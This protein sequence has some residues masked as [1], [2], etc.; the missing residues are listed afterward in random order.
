MDVK[1]TSHM[2]NG[3]GGIAGSGGS[4]G[5]AKGEDLLSESVQKRWVRMTNRFYQKIDLYDMQWDGLDTSQ[6]H[7][8]ISPFGGLIA[9]APDDSKRSINYAKPQAMALKNKV[10]VY[11]SSG[12]FVSEFRWPYKGLVGM[13]WT[14][15]EHLVVVIAEGKENIFLYSMHGECISSFGL[16]DCKTVAECSIWGSGLV[17]RAAGTKCEFYAVQN[18]RKPRITRLRSP[19]TAFKPSAMVPIPAELSSTRSLQVLLASPMGP[20]HII[21]HSEPR[22]VHGTARD[23]RAFNEPFLRM[24]LSPSGR[25]VATVNKTGTLTV[26]E[27]DF[28]TTV[29]EFITRHSKPPLD[30]AWCGE[31]SV[32]LYWE[33]ILI[34]VGPF[35]AY[36]A[37]KYPRTAPGSLK[38][39][40]E[41]DGCRVITSNKCELLRRVPEANV[42][43]FKNGS[44][45]PGALVLTASRAYERSDIAADVCIRQLK[46][47]SKDGQ[48]LL[49]EGVSTCLEAALN[50]FDTE[51][52]TALL[53]A[54]SY[55]KLFCE[56]R[57]GDLRE[58]FVERCRWVRVLHNVRS[59]SVGIP[60][61]FS[62]FE[63]LGLEVL[64][65]RLVQRHEHLLALRIC[66]LMQLN[67]NKQRVLEHWACARIRSSDTDDYRRLGEEI[68][69]KLKI[70]PGISFGKIASTA[71]TS[72]LKDLATMVLEQEPRAADQVNLLLSMEQEERALRKAVESR[73]SDLIYTVL[74]F[75]L[76][77]ARIT[78]GL[79]KARDEDEAEAQANFFSLLRRYPIVLRHLVAY[80]EGSGLDNLS[81]AGRGAV[82]ALKRLFYEMKMERE[83]AKVKVVESYLK[84][85]WKQRIRMLE[86]ATDLFKGDPFA[87]TTTKAQIRLLQIQRTFEF[88]YKKSFIDLSVS[89]TI[90][91]LIR[92]GHTDKA[93]RI[94]KEFAV[95]DKRYWH[96]Q[97]KTL[98][99]ELDWNGLS[100]LA[101]SR[102][103][104]P[105]GW[106]PFIE[107]CVDNEAISEAVKYVSKLS[108]PHD[109]MEW[110]CSMK[111]YGEAAEVAH[112]DRNVDAL[113]F[114]SSRA[115]SKPGVK[116]RIAEMIKEIGG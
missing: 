88:D 61:T 10:R 40:T 47:S 44:K 2:S 35:G 12:K 27:S 52:Q 95:P 89:E 58:D 96:I 74:L 14:N 82:E 56:D 98:A 31:D 110:F 54:A 41:L 26:L 83:A 42:R 4:S 29:S 43:T 115:K 111:C 53:R 32:L 23:E 84:Q 99:E 71:Y 106:E 109:K 7:V 20:V 75:L 30:V 60:L 100:A 70:C 108:S 92:L 76:S 15:T 114:I 28:S 19:Q 25:Y 49:R 1:E 73:D 8:A 93:N 36:V 80:Y 24:A 69:H 34:M 64:V 13:G 17:C 79:D 81:S 107:A 97:V 104:P 105:I 63:S 78:G 86:I 112:A 91:K 9:V 67:S 21:S 57:D 68:I 33:Q 72:G 90:A 66:D 85:D 46:Q 65:D 62:Q 87:S 116:A 48:E 50:S 11:T 45:D 94:R 37:F 16:R 59:T 5:K 6:A 102:R 55:G 18:F 22:E 39:H 103:S 51:V 77:R 3:G 38:L 101:S 113:R